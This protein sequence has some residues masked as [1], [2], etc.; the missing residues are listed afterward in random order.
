MKQIPHPAR[1]AYEF[2][3]MDR[4]CPNCAADPYEFCRAGHGH[5]RRVPCVARIT[6]LTPATPIPDPAPQGLP[7]AAIAAGNHIKSGGAPS[8]STPH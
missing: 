7:P 2:A 8:C 6:K 4:P 5:P 3:D 1:G